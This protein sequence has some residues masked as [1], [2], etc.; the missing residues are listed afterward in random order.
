[1]INNIFK[2]CFLIVAICL[3]LILYKIESKIKNE[4]YFV[5]TSAEGT[6]HVVDLKTAKVYRFVLGRGWVVY[7]AGENY[8]WVENPFND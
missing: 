7:S 1:M 5:S 2:A 8:K 6:Q 3:T 4:R